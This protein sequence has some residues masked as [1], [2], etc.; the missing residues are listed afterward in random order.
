MHR[1][2][3][4][5]LDLLWRKIVSIIFLHYS[6]IPGEYFGHFYLFFEKTLSSKG[7][8]FIFSYAVLEVTEVLTQKM[9]PTESTQST[10][11]TSY[12]FI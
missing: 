10:N 8:V 12:L 2:V 9:N 5:S 7:Y 11:F 1:G 3:G 4:G 6:K